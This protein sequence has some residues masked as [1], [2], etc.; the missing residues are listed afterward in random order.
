MMLS[1]DEHV[2]YRSLLTNLGE[3]EASTIT[4]APERGGTVVTDDRAA[5]NVCQELEISLTATIGILVA[6]VRDGILTQSAEDEILDLM[7]AAGFHS[8]ARRISDTL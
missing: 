6:S 1:K 7:M 5:R 3:G 4:A 2:V 8:P